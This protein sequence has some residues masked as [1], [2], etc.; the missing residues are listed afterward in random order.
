MKL[1]SG[2]WLAVGILGSLVDSTHNQKP[3][4]VHQADMANRASLNGK[5]LMNLT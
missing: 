1:L 2:I 5:R 4:F 3:L